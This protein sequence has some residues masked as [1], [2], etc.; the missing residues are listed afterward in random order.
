MA[1]L[2]PGGAPRFLDRSLHARCPLSPRAAR[3]LHLPVAS[4]S[5][6]ASSYS[7]DWP[8]LFV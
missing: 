7:A 6:L 1:V 5:V 2:A 8:L 3:R 4:S